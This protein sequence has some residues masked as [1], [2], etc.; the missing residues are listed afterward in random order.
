MVRVNDVTYS[1]HVCVLCGAWFATTV[2]FLLGSGIVCFA[3][4]AH[5]SH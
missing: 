3:S 5:A 4:G 2:L 1:M